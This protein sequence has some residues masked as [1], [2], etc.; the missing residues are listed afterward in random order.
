MSNLVTC[1]DWP[2]IFERCMASCG[3]KNIFLKTCVKEN[4]LCAQNWISVLGTL[5]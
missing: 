3:F 4:E 2:P 1:L 5:N